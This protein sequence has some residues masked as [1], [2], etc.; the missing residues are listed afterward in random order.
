MSRDPR[1]VA[2]EIH[3]QAL[4]LNYAFA[5]GV[6]LFGA[7]A[8]FYAATEGPLELVALDGVG[9]GLVAVIGIGIAAGGGVVAARLTAIPDDAE[10]WTVRQRVLTSAIVGG[11]MR[12]STGMIGAVLILSTGE[13]WIGGL[14]IA[15]S[16]VLLIVGP[17]RLDVVEAAVRRAPDLDGPN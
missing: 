5:V 17:P 3:R 8:A 1:T 4:L 13:L 2:T 16:T 14:L 7:A 11:G 15:V 10:V 9:L 6:V 12:E